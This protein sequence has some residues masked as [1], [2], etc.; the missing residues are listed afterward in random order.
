MMR[1]TVS[2]FRERLQTRDDKTFS[3]VYVAMRR[4]SEKMI[5]DSVL[6]Q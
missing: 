1:V 5:R 2:C 4:Y 3:V 6:F